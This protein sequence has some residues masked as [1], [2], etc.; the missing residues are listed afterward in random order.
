MKKP[1]RVASM[2]PVVDVEGKF[3]PHLYS[4]DVEQLQE[5]IDGCMATEYDG[6]IKFATLL[7]RF[8]DWVV[9][10]SVTAT[11]LVKMVAERQSDGNV[12]VH[13]LETG[14]SGEPYGDVLSAL[15]SCT[16][17]MVSVLFGLENL[18][19]HEQDTIDWAKGVKYWVDNF[20]FDQFEVQEY[21]D[22]GQD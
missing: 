15:A 10:E 8:L 4:T 19:Q 12:V 6:L 1:Q 17:E 2:F 16:D 13:N 18:E 5:Y 21:E 20:P 3:W 9:A 14:I 7:Q 11:Q 22:D